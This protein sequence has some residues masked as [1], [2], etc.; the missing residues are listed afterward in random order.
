[1]DKNIVHFNLEGKHIGNDTIENRIEGFDDKYFV[2]KKSNEY[3]NPMHYLITAVSGCTQLVLVSVAK[4]IGM[5][6]DS[7]QTKIN[8]EM[9]MRGVKGDPDVNTYPTYL[10]QLIEIRTSH[11][12]K[13]EELVNEFEKRCPMYNLIKDT[14]MTYIVEYKLL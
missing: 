7:L 13:L 14:V 10:H 8:C 1:M 5:E 11:P 6:L 3:L 4:E 12:D 2:S 9:D